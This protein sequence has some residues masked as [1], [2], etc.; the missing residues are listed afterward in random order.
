[1]YPK[2]RSRSSSIT[3]KA[4]GKIDCPKCGRVGQLKRRTSGYGNSYFQVDHF[5]RGNSHAS[6]Y[7]GCCYLRTCKGWEI[8]P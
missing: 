3:S 5:K 1:M 8:S 7:G 6:G 4:L 2:S